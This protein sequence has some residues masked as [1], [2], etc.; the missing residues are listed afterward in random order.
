MLHGLL[1]SFL[2]FSDQKPAALLL[3]SLAFPF[4][5]ISRTKNTIFFGIIWKYK[6]VI[7]K[8][9]ADFPSAGIFLH[10]FVQSSRPIQRISDTIRMLPHFLP[11]F[12]RF[13]SDAV[14]PFPGISQLHQPGSRQKDRPPGLSFF[15]RPLCRPMGNCG[16]FLRLETG[17]SNRQKALDHRFCRRGNSRR[18]TMRTEFVSFYNK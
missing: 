13:R 16:F 17:V 18:K 14:H 8:I 7:D 5:S 1:H 11:A 3:F 15:V 10:F 6:S 12:W 9:Q 4:F 2:A